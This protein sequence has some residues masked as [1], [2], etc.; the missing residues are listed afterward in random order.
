M[1]CNPADSLAHGDLNMKADLEV[2]SEAQDSMKLQ[3]GVYTDSKVVAMR[4]CG[5]ALDRLCRAASA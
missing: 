3:R 5:K 4:W 1:S 2:S